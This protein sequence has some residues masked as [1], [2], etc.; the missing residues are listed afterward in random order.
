MG[1]EA[2]HIPNDALFTESQLASPNNRHKIG[3]DIPI[4]GRREAY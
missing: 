2:V 4:T 3:N 1:G